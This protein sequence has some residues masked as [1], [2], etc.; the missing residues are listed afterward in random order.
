MVYFGFSLIRQNLRKLLF[1]LT[2]LINSV[3]SFG[4]EKDSCYV[5]IYVKALYDLSPSDFSFGADFYIW[6]NS[7]DS[8][9]LFR[10]IEI[11]NAKS[12]DVYSQ[13]TEEDGNSF[14]SYLNCKAQLTH[15]WDLKNYPFDNQTLE[16]QLEAQE[17][18]EY[19]YL[20]EDQ[21]GFKLDK[22]LQI[23]GWKIDNYEVMKSLVTYPSN[24]GFRHT[25]IKDKRF[26]HISFVIELSRKSWGVYFKLFMGLFI[27]FLVSYLTFFIKPIYVDPR[28]GVCIGGLFA[29]VAN[30]YVV[31]ANIPA[32][33]GFSFVDMVHLGN[34]FFI[35]ATLVLSAISLKLYTQGKE[36]K[37]KLLDRHSSIAVLICYILYN[38]ILILVA[39]V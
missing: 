29:S 27:A 31:D 34:F 19:I 35:F 1:L 11:I 25:S 5:G 38:L 36:V 8:V 18:I 10:K 2:F 21:N 20:H 15:D 6:N 3:F 26:N 23:P 17:A 37:S 30:K 32:T 4:Q 14:V 33:I 9:E 12:M 7:K 13:F 28:F 24:F 39:N 16:I 22:N